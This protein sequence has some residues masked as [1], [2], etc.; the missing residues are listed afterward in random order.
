MKR[1]VYNG[2][3]NNEEKGFDFKMF[4]KYFVEGMEQQ[5]L[6]ELPIN[7]A[8][9]EYKVKNINFFEKGDKISQYALLTTQISL[10]FRN[11]TWFL[12]ERENGFHNK[13]D[14]MACRR[15]RELSSIY[16]GRLNLKNWK[17]S[18]ANLN[19]ADL[20]F[21][22]LSFADLRGADLSYACLNFAD[23]NEAKLN[24]ANLSGADLNGANLRKA[25]L[26]KCTLRGAKYCLDKEYKTI[27]PAGFNPKEHGMIEVDIYGNPVK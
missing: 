10:A 27:F 17:L 12:T 23:L 4:V 5:I 16:C 19:E 2:K 3:A 20:S 18:I 24:G 15:F 1:P 13:D 22:D 11:L 7:K 8:V 6:S 21:A 9:K 26:F 25:D 14:N